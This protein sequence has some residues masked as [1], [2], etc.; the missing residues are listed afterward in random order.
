MSSDDVARELVQ[1]HPLQRIDSPSRGF[2]A[3]I[4]TLGLASF[5]YSFHYLVVTPNPV[6]DSY[7]WHM[8]YLTIIGLSLATLTFT[9]GLL[10][11]LTLSTRLFLAKNAFSVAS[12]PLEILITL[13][14]WGLRTI[15]VS[16]VLPDWAPR[17]AF[18]TDLS[19]HFFPAALLGVD[20]LLL[21]PPYT[22]AALPSIALSS[23][24]AVAYWFWVEA[25]YA[26][27]GF[28][29]YPIFAEAGTL[30]RVGLFVMSAV[31]MA[32]ATGLLKWVYAVV[33]GQEIWEK[34]KG[35]GAKPGD[36]KRK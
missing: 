32:S 23:L 28:Y 5:A 26:H 1:R 4:H 8:Q 35:K 20:L 11:D 19:F 31:T 36:V 16:L 21:S 2:S 29:P 13:L 30:G 27:N 12:A 25:C 18:G 14:Y 22:I 9:F 10:A 17:L 15:D 34:E 3:S 33:N 7:G 6:N 24:I